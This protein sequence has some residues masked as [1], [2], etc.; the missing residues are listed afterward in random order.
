MDMCIKK[1]NKTVFLN[2]LYKV[3]ANDQYNISVWIT[4][5]NCFKIYN[6]SLVCKAGKA[7]YI[8]LFESKYLPYPHDNEIEDWILDHEEQ[9]NLNTLLDQQY[10]NTIYTNWEIIIMSYNDVFWG[11]DREDLLLN[12]GMTRDNYEEIVRKTPHALPLR[13]SK[14]DYRGLR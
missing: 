11:I 3:F 7:A 4:G 12:G 10:K 8:S 2:E 14:P 9:L 1:N 13:F 6:N 5:N